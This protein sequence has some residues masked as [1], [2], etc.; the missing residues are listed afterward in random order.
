MIRLFHL[1]E[2]QNEIVFI[3]CKKKK[4]KSHLR[5]YTYEYEHNIY[6]YLF[7]PISP[8]LDINDYSNIVLKNLLT[9]YIK[10]RGGEGKKKEENA[11]RCK[12]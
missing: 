9:F 11:Y 6:L 2:K 5:T 1:T 10:K 4:L 8:T 7:L 3:V 12:I